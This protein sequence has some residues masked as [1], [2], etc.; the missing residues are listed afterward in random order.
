[1]SKWRVVIEVEG[2]GEEVGDH[3]KS[4]IED[5]CMYGPEVTVVSEELLPDE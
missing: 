1:M 2:L 5:G 3:I 4:H